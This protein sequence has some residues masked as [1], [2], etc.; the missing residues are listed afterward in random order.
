MRIAYFDIT[1]G[2]S[3]DMTLAALI[4]AGVS[5][6]DLRAQLAGLA[7]GQWELK[8]Q[9]VHKQGIAAAHV[10]VTAAHGEEHQGGGHGRPYPQLRQLLEQAQIDEQV[11]AQAAAMLDMLAQAE[12]QVHGVDKNQVHFHEVGGLDTLVDLA[13][14]AA[15]LKLLGVEAVHCSPIPWTHGFVETAHGRLPVPAPATAKLLEALPIRGLDIEGETVTPTGAVICRYYGRSFGPP[16][17]MSVE[18]IGLGA[19]TA[20]F[21]P[22]PNILRVLVGKPASHYAAVDLLADSVVLISTNIDDMQP[23]LY[24]SLMEAAFEAGALDV[25][26]VPAFMKHNRPAVQV[27][28]LASPSDAR[29]VAQAIFEHSTTLGVRM[30]E[31]TRM[32]LPRENR[33]VQTEFGP[34]SVKIARMGGRVISAQPEYRQCAE[35]ARRC[36]VPVRR[37]YAAALAEAVKLIDNS[38]QTDK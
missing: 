18:A 16:P 34:I 22:I 11:K 27:N 15:A 4:D 28:A 8:V 33:Q 23:E 30:S 1:C 38:A 32:C 13:G 21:P 6:E 29:A 9:R 37:V 24:E 17:T 31:M 25:W 26:L 5:P 36:G 10:Q 12:A 2:I 7:P 35:A 20:D 14:V 19:G 3:G